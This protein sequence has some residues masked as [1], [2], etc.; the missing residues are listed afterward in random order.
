MESPPR[1]VILISENESQRITQRSP[2]LEE[3]IN[4]TNN[5]AKVD[6][7]IEDSDC[8][9][10]D[11]NDEDIDYYAYEKDKEINRD[12]VS[13]FHNYC[14]IIPIQIFYL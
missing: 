10:G 9:I 8:F 6:N 13:L 14:I 7:N 12:F 2:L 4:S 1:S 11:D 3:S 5:T